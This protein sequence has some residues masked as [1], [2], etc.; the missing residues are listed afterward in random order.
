MVTEIPTILKLNSKDDIIA[1]MQDTDILD[2]DKVAMFL[3]PGY[4]TE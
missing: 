3:G 2:P 1:R 4:G